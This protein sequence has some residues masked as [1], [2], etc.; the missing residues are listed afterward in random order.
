[1]TPVKS[2]IHTSPFRQLLKTGLSCCLLT[3]AA[4]TSA[5]ADKGS[6]TITS[7]GTQDVWIGSYDWDDIAY[8]IAYESDTFSTGT[9]ETLECVE[10]LFESS[11]PGCQLVIKD[12]T[13][14]G[15]QLALWKVDNGTY[16]LG[17]SETTTEL[18]DGCTTS[19][20]SVCLK[21]QSSCSSDQSDNTSSC[22][23]SES[24]TYAITSC[25]SVDVTE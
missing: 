24:F 11:S 3:L 25:I 2:D 8:K 19:V 16:T 18:S 23:Q 12:G 10:N 13:S 17:S 4:L 21:E 15:I 20:T 1:M 5:L 6:V 9:S 7:C 22:D 14:A